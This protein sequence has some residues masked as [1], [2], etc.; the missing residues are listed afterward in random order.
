MLIVA[1]ELKGMK[2]NIME[3]VEGSKYSIAYYEP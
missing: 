3:A 2:E 1:K